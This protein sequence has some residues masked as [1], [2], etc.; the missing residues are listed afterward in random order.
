M[1][2][3]AMNRGHSI[4]GWCVG[5]IVNTMNRGGNRMRLART[6]LLC[7]ALAGTAGCSVREYAL[8][9]I[10]D[11]LASGGDAYSS[12]E[13]IELVGAA[14][15]FGLKTIESL[16]AEVPDHKGLLLAAARGFTQYS[17]VYVQAPAEEAEERDVKYAYQQQARARKLYLR[18][19]DYGL[20]GL[21]VDKNDVGLLYWTAVAWAAAISLSK[22]DPATLAGLPQVDALIARAVAINPDY[23]HGALRSFLIGYEMS[24]P[25]AP[26]GAEARARVHFARAVELSAGKQASPYVSLAE[27]VAVESRNRAEFEA[28]LKQAI[29]LD[30]GARPEWR[31]ANFVMQRRA[32]RLLARADE[33]FP[34]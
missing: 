32:R 33:L 11:A 23:D 26:A 14:T 16:L 30:P 24:R 28:L 10:G 7:C 22:D 13:D 9:S 19:R 27:S 4:A 17:Y 2:R 34:E 12:D 1:T 29:L 25:G 5:T 31:L 18:A 15:P 8:R 6:L 20:R 3:P 21:A